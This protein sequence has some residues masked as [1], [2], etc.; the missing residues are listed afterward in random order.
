MF[1]LSC[2]VHSVSMWGFVEFC[3]SLE[4]ACIFKK[5]QYLWPKQYE[6]NM[7]FVT[8]NNRSL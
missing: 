5:P 3:W 1:Y 6:N 4:G 8:W 7:S 2:V